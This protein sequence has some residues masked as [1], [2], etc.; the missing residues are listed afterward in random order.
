MWQA[1]DIA[2]F[3]ARTN[4]VIT[5]L[6]GKLNALH[7]TLGLKVSELKYTNGADEITKLL[8]LNVELVLLVESVIYDVS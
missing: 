1:L 2:F 8:G 4:E 7:E 3:Q 6:L 5:T